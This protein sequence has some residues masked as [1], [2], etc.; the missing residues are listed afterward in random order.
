MQSTWEQQLRKIM[1]PLQ[2][3]TLFT[4]CGEKKQNG[5]CTS[6]VHLDMCKLLCSGELENLPFLYLL[7][8]LYTMYH[9]L[10]KLQLYFFC[11]LWLT[12]IVWFALS[13]IELYLSWSKAKKLACCWSGHVSSSITRVTPSVSVLPTIEEGGMEKGR[14][15]SN[16]GLIKN[17]QWLQKLKGS[18]LIRGENGFAGP[19]FF[20][21]LSW[22]CW[23]RAAW[24]HD[25]V[26]IKQM[27]NAGFG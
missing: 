6:W 22:C 18:A 8:S 15:R 7:Q 4:K 21:R 3:L 1:I 19:S 23:K 13:C 26:G 20:Q 2:P 5:L 24:K 16:L 11:L 12:S 10:W 25:I 14:Y 27:Q 9:L 17:E